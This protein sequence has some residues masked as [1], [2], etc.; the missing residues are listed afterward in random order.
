[1]GSSELDDE[2]LLEEVRNQEEEADAKHQAWLEDQAA[3][4]RSVSFAGIQPQPGRGGARGR[5][6]GRSGRC[7]VGPSADCAYTGK[8]F[9]G[10]ML[11]PSEVVARLK[12]EIEASGSDNPEADL[13]SSLAALSAAA[14]AEVLRLQGEGPSSLI[15]NQNR[16]PRLNPPKSV[17]FQRPE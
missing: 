4:M 8:G 11:T 7:G 16:D 6:R 1:M 17:R 9:T 3:A 13:D 5:G 12:D 15:H 2:L 10:T 14:Q